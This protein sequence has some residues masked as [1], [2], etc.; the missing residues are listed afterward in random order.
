M[1]RKINRCGKDD[2]YCLAGASI[3]TPMNLTVGLKE[4]ATEPQNGLYNV[5]GAKQRI[6]T[7]AHKLE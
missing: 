3:I 4:R 7:H 1:M 5:L 6:E 2:G